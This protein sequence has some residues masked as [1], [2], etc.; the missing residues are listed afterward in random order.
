MLLHQLQNL[1]DDELPTLRSIRE[2]QGDPIPWIAVRELKLFVT[3][4]DPADGHAVLVCPSCGL[5]ITIAFTCKR[6]SFCPCC[7]E[8]RREDR[9][10][11]LLERVLPDQAY[12]HWVLTMP[13]ELRHNL[14]Y[15]PALVVAVRRCLVAAI[16]KYLKRKALKTVSGLTEDMFHAGAIIFGHPVSANLDSNFHL[17]GVF[18]D[19]VYVERVR[20]GP[21]EFLPVDGP[22]DE[23]LARVAEEVCVSVCKMLARRD[24]WKD[25]PGFVVLGGVR[26][27][28]S[29]RNPEGKKR[30]W[31][32]VTYVGRA[33]GTDPDDR[34][35]E[36][37]DL[38]AGD[39]VKKGDRKGLEHLVRYLLSPPFK[40]D[41]LTFDEHG[42]V[43][44]RL[45][46]PRR[47]GTMY[48]KFTPHEFILALIN[49][50]PRPRTHAVGYHGVL[51]R[52]A[53]LRSKVVPPPAK[54]SRRDKS[55]VCQETTSADRDAWKQLHT[56]APR[57]RFL[58]CPGC[59]DRL[60]LVQLVGEELDYHNSQ[61][62]P[63]DI[64]SG[65]AAEP[66]IN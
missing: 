61:W 18:L 56:R 48:V 33:V 22:T 47:D 1:V 66:V 65:P 59:H 51:G 32:S 40:L 29:L 54:K 9:T 2:A 60:E 46:R 24:M 11:H 52:N 25:E 23:E 42:N 12:R 55:C 28:I 10:H 30:R 21:I 43:I 36:P 5:R 41:Q 57:E 63:P 13:A 39:R 8:R 27:R 16:T 64:P 19:G 6:R 3:C 31:H 4:E 14:R 38:Y 26:G 34:S 35:G 17:H 37:F 7:I 49:L 50:I 15:L 45:R 58:R 44:L 53:R 62:L 20:G